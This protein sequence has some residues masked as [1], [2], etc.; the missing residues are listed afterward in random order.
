M[1]EGQLENVCG[2]ERFR[3]EPTGLRDGLQYATPGYTSK[4]RPA[5]T[6]NVWLS[7]KCQLSQR[8]LATSVAT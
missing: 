5:Y 3:R 1:T 8:I 4:M 2:R 6:S 7:V